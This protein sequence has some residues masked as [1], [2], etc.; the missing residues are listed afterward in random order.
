[1]WTFLHERR[2]DCR[3]RIAGGLND[4]KQFCVVVAV[5]VLGGIGLMTWAAWAQP[6]ASF[7]VAKRLLAEAHEATGHERTLYCG[8]PYERRGKSGGDLE[9]EACGLRA[10]RNDKRSDRLEW[11]NVVCAWRGGK[12]RP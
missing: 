1:M 8:C 9:R 4:A 5:A 12:D 10:R 7:Q 3:G 11:E 2:Q 6:P